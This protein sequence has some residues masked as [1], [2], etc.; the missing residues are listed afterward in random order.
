[1]CD[2]EGQV[3]VSATDQLRTELRTGRPDPLPTFD[4]GP[5]IETIL[6][7]ALAETGLPAPRPPVAR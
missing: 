1:V 4:S 3:D 6:A 5:A 7:N 2:E